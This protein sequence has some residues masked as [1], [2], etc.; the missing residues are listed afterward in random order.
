MLSFETLD[1]L[2]ENHNALGTAKR[3]INRHELGLQ[4][5]TFLNNLERVAILWELLDKNKWRH[6]VQ[7]YG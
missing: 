4:M 3:P 6:R 1:L 7:F 5:E 2:A